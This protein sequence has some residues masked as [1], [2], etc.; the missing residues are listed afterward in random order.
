MFSGR[1]KG[2]IEK[3]RLVVLD[4]ILHSP[5]FRFASMIQISSTYPTEYLEIN[6]FPCLDYHFSELSNL[7]DQLQL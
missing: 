3:K 2:N 1:S 4:F 6:N 5:K 7:N